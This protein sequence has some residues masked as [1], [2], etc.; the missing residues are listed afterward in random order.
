MTLFVKEGSHRVVCR[1][2]GQDHSRKGSGNP[3]VLR[4][5]SSKKIGKPKSFDRIFGR[6]FEGSSWI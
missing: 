3:N 5:H 4:K 1:K 2:S 6:T